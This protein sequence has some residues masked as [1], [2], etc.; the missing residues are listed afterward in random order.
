[1]KPTT[2]KT[3]DPRRNEVL[4]LVRR[5]LLADS[6]TKEDVKK[7]KAALGADVVDELVKEFAPQ[8]AAKVAPS[9]KA[10]SK[11]KSAAPEKE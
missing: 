4:S 9:K 2:L 7:W 6:F 8:K 1:M 10:E 5:Q 3:H 11:D